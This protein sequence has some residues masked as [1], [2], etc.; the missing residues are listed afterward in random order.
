[1][2]LTLTQGMDL[3][4]HSYL[5]FGTRSGPEYSTEEDT[6][7]TVESCTEIDYIY[8]LHNFFAT[9]PISFVLEIIYNVLQLS[10]LDYS[11]NSLSFNS[12]NIYCIKTFFK[13][14][15]LAHHKTYTLC[16]API[17]ILMLSHL[18]ENG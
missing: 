8:F 4:L 11:W 10:Q 14:A 1:M 15:I 5:F 18:P 2:C 6:F 12:L 9:L 17:V 13:I 7:T 16:E 3:H